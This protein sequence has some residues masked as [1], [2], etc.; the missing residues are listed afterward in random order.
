MTKVLRAVFVIAITMVV[1]NAQEKK[2]TREKLPPAVE[3]TVAKESQGATVK[4]FSTET[5]HRQRF[6]EVSLLVD[7]HNKDISID[8]DGNVVEIEEQ[9]TLESLP[10]GA[11]ESIKKTA[12]GGTIEM[13]ES[14]T[15]KG[16]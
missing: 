8:K 9:V 14:L 4:G 10:E 15:K 6:Y 1:S 5:E 16:T 7:G 3:K 11:Q 2:I 12:N 13:I